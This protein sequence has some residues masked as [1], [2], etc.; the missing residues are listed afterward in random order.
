MQL[1][2]HDGRESNHLLA[3]DS[4]CFPHRAAQSVERE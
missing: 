3:L 2:V 1:I 4:R